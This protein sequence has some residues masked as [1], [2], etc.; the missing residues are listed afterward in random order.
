MLENSK[1][2]AKLN[3]KNKSDSFVREVD[4]LELKKTELERDQHKWNIEKLTLSTEVQELN[5]K[6]KAN[7][8]ESSRREKILE[9]KMQSEMQL[10]V[11]NY[12]EQYELM[13]NENHK[14][15]NQNLYYEKEMQDLRLEHE[16]VNRLV[17]SSFYHL[18]QIQVHREKAHAKR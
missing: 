3:N 6:L 2:Q 16:R 10:E 15:K 14:V 12:E 5:R 4:Q 1:L 18:G 8:E 7:E 9:K 13:M 17:S 11:D